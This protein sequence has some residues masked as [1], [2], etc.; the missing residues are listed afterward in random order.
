MRAFLAL[1]FVF[2]LTACAPGNAPPRAMGGVLDL[3]AWTFARPVPLAGEWDVHWGTLFDDAARSEPARFEVPNRWNGARLP[4]G[5]TMDADGCATFHLRVLLPPRDPKEPWAIY[6][7][8]ADSAYRLVI[9][10]E[11]GRLIAPPATAGSPACA[12]AE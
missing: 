8:I 5:G 1:L 9:R 3:R 6:L 7:R 4:D 10:D 12:R 2:A 11:S